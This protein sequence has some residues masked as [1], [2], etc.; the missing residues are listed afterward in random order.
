MTIS[1]KFADNGATVGVITF[2]DES[3]TP[4]LKPGV[5]SV[6][7]SMEGFYLNKKGPR[8]SAPTKLYGNVQQ[9]VDKVINTYNSAT[10]SFGVLL[11]GDKGSGKT[12]ASSLIAN[13]AI[14]DLGLPVILVEQSFPAGGLSSFIERL[15]ECVVFFDEFGK[16]F[17]SDDEDQGNLLSLF[18]GTGSG[19]RLVLLTENERHNINNYMLNRPGRIWY[20]FEY[21]KLDEQTIAQYCDEHEIDE[22]TVEKIK[23]RCIKSYDFSF[24]IL[25]AIV[26]EYKMYGGDVD[27]LCRDLN[28]QKIS[29]PAP[30]EVEFIETIVVR[31][32]EEVKIFED[33]YEFPVTGKDT[34]VL[35]SSNTD[36]DGDSLE[37]QEKVPSWLKDKFYLEMK[38]LVRKEGDIYFFKAKRSSDGEE[39]LVRCCRKET[40]NPNAY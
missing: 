11:S 32:G 35:I 36:A 26:A 22:D 6:G 14:D 34:K 16:K 23:F 4:K 9:R 28:V 10:S 17:D 12:L 18:D 19:R 20:H 3:I 13:K 2:D 27:E 24:D 8:M 15:G 39:L 31:T 33:Q 30:V 5:Y 29:Q 25:Q 37:G 40:T 1:T 7:L 21:G 38:H